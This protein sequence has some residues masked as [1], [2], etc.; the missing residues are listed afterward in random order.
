MA[1]SSREMPPPPLSGVV[2]GRIAKTALFTALVIFSSVAGNAFLSWGMKR[3]P[4]AASLPIP[5]F[6]LPFLSPTVW[7]GI[8]LL[9]IWM[10]SRM[11]LL[12]WADLS[13]VVPVTSLGYVLNVASGALILGESVDGK[14]WL[15]ALLIVGGSI[16]TGL[17]IG[18]Q[19]KAPSPIEPEPSSEPALA[20]KH[21]GGAA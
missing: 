6:F 7:L 14:R 18:Q 4:V 13:F 10:L 16:L 2:S 20:A 17:T 12:S 15:G 5:D 21:P 9:I 8:A 3:V 1:A 19:S 11:M